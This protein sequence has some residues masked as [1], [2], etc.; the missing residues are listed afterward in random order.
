MLV[1]VQAAD[2]AATLARELKLGGMRCVASNWRARALSLSIS[3]LK[4]CLCNGSAAALHGSMA[5]ADRE[6][7]VEQFRSGELFVLVA[8]DLLAR[9]VDYRA[10]ETVVN[11]DVPQSVEE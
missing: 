6:H 9:G 4:R 1:F 11:F 2:R 7:V 8:T 5:Q 10:V 3:R